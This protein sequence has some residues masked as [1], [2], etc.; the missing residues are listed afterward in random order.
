M[1]RVLIHQGPLRIKALVEKLGLADRLQ[2]EH[3]SICHLCWDIFRDDDLAAKLRAAME[4]EQL[5]FLIAQLS[6][7]SSE[8]VPA[9]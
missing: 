4:E 8:A 9:P 5:A 1:L 2:P 6:A 7:A 3:S